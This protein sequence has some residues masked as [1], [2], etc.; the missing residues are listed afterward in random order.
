[1]SPPPAANSGAGFALPAPRFSG[2][3]RRLTLGLLI[4]VGIAIR[5]FC[6][7]CKP[8]WFDECFSVEVARL[9]W[10]N[11]V[12]LMWWREANM[13]FYYLLLR[14]WLHFGQR[15]FFIR[16]LSVIFSVATIPAIYWLARSLYNRRVALIACALLTV[17]AYDLRYAQEARSYSLL[18][19]LATL[20]SG[21]L[22]SWL[23]QPTRRSLVAYVITSCLAMY[24]HFYALLLLASQ[25]LAVLGMGNFQLAGERELRGRELRRAWIIIAAAIFPLLL[26]IAKTGA[27]PIRWI[28]RPGIRDVLQ[29]FEHLAGGRNWMPLTI[30]AA[31]CAAALIPAGEGLL[32]RAHNWETWRCQFLLIWLLFPILLTVLLSIARPLFL[33]RYMIFCL[34]AFLILAS[35]GIARLRQWWSVGIVLVAALFFCARGVVFVYG[36][37]FDT[38]RDASGNA[39]DFILDHSDPSDAIIF[40]I[41]GTRIP[42]EFF[43]S[44]RAGQNTANPT[45][46]GQLGPVIVFPHHGPGLEYTDFTGKPAPEFVRSVGEKYPRVWVMLMNNGQR[47][48]PDPTT[49]MLSQLLSEVFPKVQIWEFARVEVRLYSR[50]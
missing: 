41:A 21:F 24:A 39:A 2:L 4:S 14:G 28:T 33:P 38:E 31:A 30:L 1:M 34:P 3:A 18:V 25:W 10:R 8:F 7:G 48:N 16:S 12:H 43:R 45:F 40:H 19:L 35:A 32:N 5:L 15:P 22:I 13:S 20:S 50:K 42:Y 26:F 11:F 17:N 37:D 36:H 49:V 47:G 27:G 46:N 29:L 44:L 23:R 9:D 6:L